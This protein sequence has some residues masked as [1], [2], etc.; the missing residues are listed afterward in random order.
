MCTALKAGALLK[1]GQKKEAAY[2]FS[3][4]F[5]GGKA[6]KVSN[7]LGFRWSVQNN[8]DSAK[9]DEPAFLQQCKS[10]KERATMMALFAMHGQATRVNDIRKIYALNPAAEELE[11]EGIHAEVIDL[12]SIRPLDTKTIIESVKKTN[13]LVVIDESW[14]FAS[15]SSEIAYRVQKDAFDYLDAPVLRVNGSDVSMPYKPLSLI[16]Q[17]PFTG[18]SQPLINCVRRFVTE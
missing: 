9:V 2:F 8:N 5:A 18:D 4:A 12:R 11:K 3:K 15:V 17:K 14:P 7:F 16:P 6:K 10:D 13:R 1:L